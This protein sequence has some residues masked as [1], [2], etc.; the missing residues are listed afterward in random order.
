MRH[1]DKGQQQAI[2]VVIFCGIL[3]L[4]CCLFLAYY[5]EIMNFLNNP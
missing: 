5:D 1:Y 3:I 2:A 4:A